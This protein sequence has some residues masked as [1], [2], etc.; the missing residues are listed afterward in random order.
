MAA[1]LL[2]TS[3][4]ISLSPG[5][6]KPRARSEFRCSNRVGLLVSGTYLG[7]KG[8]DALTGEHGAGDEA[9]EEGQDET[10]E[11]GQGGQRP[12]VADG[13]RDRDAVVVGPGDGGIECA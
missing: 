12:V 11:E 8:G 3:F 5:G 9:G 7:A 13:D 10:G 6:S 1:L 4:L 2:S